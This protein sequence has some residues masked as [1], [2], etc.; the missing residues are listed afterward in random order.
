MGQLCRGRDSREARNECGNADKTLGG[1]GSSF[2][3][4]GGVGF[5]GRV[6]RVKHLAVI[7]VII[8]QNVRKCKPIHA[9]LTE[10]DLPPPLLFDLK[11]S[12]KKGFLL[13]AEAKKS[14]VKRR[15]A[16]VP[17]DSSGSQHPKGERSGLPSGRV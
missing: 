8:Y 11:G 14:A 15:D 10:L 4:R 5:F 17:T 16:Q 1:L 2:P 7:I 9:Y 12:M 13:R 3:K 6:P